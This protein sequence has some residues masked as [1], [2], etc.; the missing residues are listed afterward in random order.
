MLCTS[1]GH[2]LNA[3]IGTAVPKLLALANQ[4][5]VGPK[6]EAA[7]EAVALLALSVQEDGLHLLVSELHRALEDPSRRRAAADLISHLAAH[8]KVIKCGGILISHVAAHCKVSV[9]KNVRG[10]DFHASS[11]LAPPP[12]VHCAPNPPST[13]PL[14]S[15]TCRSTCP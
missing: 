8:C 14:L 11:R 2:T 13:P 3:H 7:R 10:C 6:E 15:M 12:S 4:P 5:E 1:A 9:G